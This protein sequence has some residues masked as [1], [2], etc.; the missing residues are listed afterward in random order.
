MKEGKK[1]GRKRERKKRKQKRK[2]EEKKEQKKRE[3]NGKKPVTHEILMQFLWTLTFSL[4]YGYITV[5][6]A[7]SRK[8]FSMSSTHLHCTSDSRKGDT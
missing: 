1:E 7:P 6:K 8:A 5:S 2:K 4:L 3:Q